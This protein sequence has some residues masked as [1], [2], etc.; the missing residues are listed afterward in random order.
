MS[1]PID[2]KKLEILNKMELLG[3]EA[4]SVITHLEALGFKDRALG[5]SLIADEL[6]EEKFKIAAEMPEAGAIHLAAIEKT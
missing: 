5:L 2:K 3:R 4:S 6:A 1:M